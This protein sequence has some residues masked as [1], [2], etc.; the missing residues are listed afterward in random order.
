MLPKPADT[1]WHSD[2]QWDEFAG[3][4]GPG[5]TNRLKS[6]ERAVFALTQVNRML[7]A[8]QCGKS[9]AENFSEIGFEGFTPVQVEVLHIAAIELGA[10]AEM[11]INELRDNDHGCLD[12]LVGVSQ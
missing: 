6:I 11:S 7:F 2:A 1:R 3:S 12:H 8:D 9:E 5:V 4:L 10:A